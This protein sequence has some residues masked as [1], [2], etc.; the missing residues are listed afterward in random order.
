MTER[1]LQNMGYPHEKK[2]VDL[3]IFDANCS[4]LRYFHPAKFT[5]LIWQTN[6]EM[7]LEEKMK[8]IEPYF[9]YEGFEKQARE[10]E[11]LRQ[12]VI[13]LGF[14]EAAE[15]HCEAVKLTKMKEDAERHER[16]ERDREKEFF[17]QMRRKR[18]VMTH[19]EELEME[20]KAFEKG[21]VRI[22]VDKF[23]H[24]SDANKLAQEVAGGLATLQQFID[25]EVNSGD[26]TDFWNYY[27]TD[28]GEPDVLQLGNHDTNPKRYLTHLEKWGKCGWLE[29]G[30]C[31]GHWRVLG[32]F[33]AKRDPIKNPEFI[34]TPD[35][36]IPEKGE[37]GHEEEE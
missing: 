25:S 2:D 27:I 26:K 28:D 1:Y 3:L 9:V 21:I 33:Y 32:F 10:D 29:N 5:R 6:K 30:H 35:I 36:K 31:F 37:E 11:F 19:E 4:H 15:K 18:E 17:N 16:N 14:Y 23:L 7:T 12:E 13:E 20:R 22:N 8:T 24:W 34:P